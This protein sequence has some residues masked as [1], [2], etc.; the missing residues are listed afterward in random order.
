MFEDTAMLTIYASLNTAIILLL[1][2][3]WHVFGIEEQ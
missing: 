2:F 1:M 3:A